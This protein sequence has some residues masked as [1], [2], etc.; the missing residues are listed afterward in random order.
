MFSE[1]ISV[2]VTVADCGIKVILPNSDETPMRLKG[3][4]RVPSCACEFDEC[5]FECLDKHKKKY[6]KV[7]LKYF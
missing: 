4:S 7:F 6:F 2:W 1:T 3:Y 5:A